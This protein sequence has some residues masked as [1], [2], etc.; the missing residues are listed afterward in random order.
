[1][2]RATKRDVWYT[3]MDHNNFV[4]WYFVGFDQPGQ[5]WIDHH[6][7]CIRIFKNSFDDFFL[8]FSWSFWYGVKCGDNF[9]FYLLKKLNNITTV[10]TT[11][12]TK[13]VLQT[14]YLC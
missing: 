9:L 12:Q 2:L 6:H 1:M 3:M 8:P 13:L 10:L 14:D 11:K 4:F 5:Y 7:Y